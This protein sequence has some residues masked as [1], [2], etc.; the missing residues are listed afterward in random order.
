MIL[1]VTST[2]VAQSVHSSS[3]GD[4]ISES[5]REMRT[6]PPPNQDPAKPRTASSEQGTVKRP[7]VQVRHRK[8][9]DGKFWAVTGMLVGSTI[10]DIESSHQ[11]CLQTNTC[12]EGNKLLGS[13]RGRQYAIKMSFSAVMLAITYKL[14]K[15]Q[16][17]LRETHQREGWE[18]KEGGLAWDWWWPAALPTGM[19]TAAG[20]HNV[21]RFRNTKP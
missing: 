17:S 20:T 15:E 10:F 6:I 4:W 11:R 12:A 3:A 19:F 2:C 7:A 13:G 16:D 1:F 14:K 5:V 9:L 21:V 18:E 8:T